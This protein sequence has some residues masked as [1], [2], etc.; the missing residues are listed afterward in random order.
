MGKA[1]YPAFIHVA[2]H[3]PGGALLGEYHGDISAG[4]GGGQRRRNP[5]G[6]HGQHQIRLFLRKL[7]RECLPH[8]D[9]QVRVQ[10]VIEKHIHLDDIRTHTHA[11]RADGLDQLPHAGCSS[12]AYG[13]ARKAGVLR[14]ACRAL[15]LLLLYRISLQNQ[16]FA[17]LE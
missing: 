10:P 17:H 8:L 7:L 3:I 4:H 1:E 14:R 11:P 2:R 13:N 5:A 16:A 9:K 6:L 15:F 12:F